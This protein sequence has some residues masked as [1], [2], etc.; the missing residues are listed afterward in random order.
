[1]FGVNKTQK[2][3]LS[4][5]HLPVAMFVK[6]PF[7]FLAKTPRDTSRNTKEET[8]SGFQDWPPQLQAAESAP[9]A[10]KLMQRTCPKSLIQS[11][12]LRIKAAQKSLK[13]QGYAQ[14]ISHT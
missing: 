6:L 1:M 11:L 5:H 8:L 3:N 7:L 13:A 4:K 14:C 10:L 2:T 12:F 9:L